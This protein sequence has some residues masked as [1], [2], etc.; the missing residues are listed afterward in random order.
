MSQ[1]LN[2]IKQTAKTK[3]YSPRTA[4]KYAEWARN[5]I[6]FHNKRHPRE[7]GRFEIEKYLSYL[8][9]T[10]NLSASSR[11]QCYYALKF[12]YVHVLGFSF[13][14]VQGLAAKESKRLPTVLSRD[15]VRKVLDCI[16]GDP[17]NLM[18]RLMYGAGLRLAECQALR[19]KDIEF[20]TSI[21][22]VRGGK[23]DK[24]RTVPLPKTLVKPLM[25]QMAIARRLHEIDVQKGMPGVYV[26]GVLDRKYPNIGCELG[27]FWVFPAQNYSMDPETKTRRRH[28]QHESEI[29]RAIRAGG[30]KA[31]VL[32]RV[33]P[34]VFRHSFATH[35]L[36]AGYDVRTVQELM[37]HKDL[38][39]T[40]VYLHILNPGSWAGVESPLDKM[41]AESLIGR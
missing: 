8:A 10:C 2:S 39:T 12:M 22:T 7:M 3:N 32:A 16:T 1:L 28:H 27:W 36:W 38:K 24:D 4:E 13:E 18:A 11:N 9:N 5:F 33:S 14:D 23:G 25:D 6:L 26:P 37:G 21:I 29:Q 40:M 31:G 34:H 30:I 41:S 17:F 15:D 20:S 35:L 19:F